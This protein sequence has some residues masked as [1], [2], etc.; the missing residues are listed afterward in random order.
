MQEERDYLVKFVFPELRRRCRSRGLEFTE[1]DL[2]WGVTEEQAERGEV[3]PLCLAEIDKCRPYFI[4][5]LGQRYGHVPA[6]MHPEL[7]V[8]QPWISNF[9]ERSITELEILHGALKTPE[10]ASRSFFYFRDP[11]YLDKVPAERREDY[12]S[13]DTASEAKLV[14]LKDQI[15]KSGHV[16]RE[17]FSDPQ[18]LGEMV[19][20][21][22]WE[23][24]TKEFPES[25]EPNR[26]DLMVAEHE[27]FARSRAH[28]YIGR[29]EYFDRLNT[30]AGDNG[31][32][33]VILGESGSG[34]SAL[35][36]NWGLKYREEHPKDFVFFHFAGSSPNSTDH[37]GLLSRLLA[38]LKRRYGF[39]E[40]VP[41]DSDKLRD[42]VPTW[43]ARAG[44]GE[45]RS[46]IILDGLN[47]LEDRDNALDLGWLPEHFPPQVCLIVST[48][49]GR[50]LAEIE[51]RKWQRLAVAA[52][53]VEERR[54]L[55]R[56]YLG[57]YRK[58]LNDKRVAQITSSLQTANPLYLRALLDELRVFGIHAKL[59][60]RIAHYLGA[61]SVPELYGLIL[62]RYEQDYE[63]D[64]PALVRDTM[65]LICSS[66]LGLPESELTLLL[67]TS[68]RP[69]PQAIWAPLYLAAEQNIVSRSGLLGF[70]HDFFR[71]AVAHRYLLSP[72]AKQ[73]AH[74]TLAQHFSSLQMGERKVAELPWQF[75]TAG[76]HENLKSCLTDP[77]LLIA[78]VKKGRLSDMGVYWTSL[79]HEYDPVPTYVNAAKRLKQSSEDDRAYSVYVGAVGQ[80]LE[81]LGSYKDAENFYGERLRTEIQL[82]KTA[83]IF[84]SANRLV[85]V[86][87]KQNKLTEAL[88]LVAGVYEGVKLEPNGGNGPGTIEFLIRM[89]DLYA[90]KGYFEAATETLGTAEALVNEDSNLSASTKG[91]LL[92]TQASIVIRFSKEITVRD[93]FTQN[94]LSGKDPKTTALQTVDFMRRE[95]GPRHPDYVSALRD[96]TQA[97]L[98]TKE[99]N[100]AMEV[101]AEAF[102]CS[103]LVFGAE[104]AETGKSMVCLADVYFETGQLERA[105]FLY[106]KAVRI[107]QMNSIDTFDH[108]RAVSRLAA[109]CRI[110]GR[111]AEVN[112]F[113]TMLDHLRKVSAVK[114]GSL[115]IGQY[116]ARTASPA[117]R[118]T[119]SVEPGFW[120]LMKKIRSF[121][122]SLIDKIGLNP[123]KI[124]VSLLG[125]ALSTGMALF[126]FGPFM[127]FLASHG[128]VGLIKMIVFGIG[129]F[130]LVLSLIGG[131]MSFFEAILGNPKEG[132]SIHFLG[133]SLAYLSYAGCFFL[134]R[135]Y[136]HQI[137]SE[138]TSVVVV[139]LGIIIFISSLIGILSHKTTS[140]LQE[141]TG[142]W[143]LPRF[144]LILPKS[145]LLPGALTKIGPRASSL[146]KSE[147]VDILFGNENVSQLNTS[148]ELPEGLLVYERLNSHIAGDSPITQAPDT[149]HHTVWFAVKA[150]LIAPVL[151]LFPSLCELLPVGVRPDN[152]TA[153][154]YANAILILFYVFFGNRMGRRSIALGKI[155]TIPVIGEIIA[156]KPPGFGIIFSLNFTVVTAVIATLTI[157]AAQGKLAGPD[158][159]NAFAW[160]LKAYILLLISYGVTKAFI[161]KISK[162]GVPANSAEE[163][164]KSAFSIVFA[165]VG[166]LFFPVILLLGRTILKNFGVEGAA[167]DWWP[168][169]M[170]ALSSVAFVVFGI[171]MARRRLSALKT[172]SVQIPMLFVAMLGVQLILGKTSGQLL[173][174]ATA[175]AG[176]FG[177]IVIVSFWLM[178][179]IHYRRKSKY[180]RSIQKSL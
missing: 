68:D 93:V 46:I 129:H 38:E 137:P 53:G 82:D 47:Q 76:D 166:G 145:M 170:F 59:D 102:T 94:D 39:T 172:M 128:D 92:R 48:L 141:S 180:D 54:Q 103:E 70:F 62:E 66:R 160:N 126:A 121:A 123:S 90:E 97:Y 157:L 164:E 20:A 110:T 162:L 17:R 133:K 96:L 179:R 75:Y 158:L 78:A 37:V 16:V 9:K 98:L 81:Y 63:Q 12:L 83:E 176:V 26:L 101:A 19:L 177:L 125:V 151:M 73:Q 104:H 178:R 87:A 131:Y 18:T 116:D 111:N 77:Q 64:R 147:L 169:L 152:R 79:K 44:A 88:K 130:A 28:V 32:P 119:S 142:R 49:P 50:S 89:A 108:A 175:A 155:L 51:R 135:D 107:F 122:M 15:R 156:R 6:E 118:L 120:R 149:K 36:A 117:D 134:L 52:L 42:A 11:G 56:D 115:N 5:I 95:F 150:G 13:E 80:V 41:A 34:K 74:R 25:G 23:A 60:E 72:E 124:I 4:G 31:M 30:H 21:D 29:Q 106:T 114:L 113:E 45:G 8:E 57:Q 173:A 171:E 35:L 136:L 99:N 71:Q 10:T 148:I 109:I 40:E 7:L 1:V 163:I 146:S 165:V 84:E 67:G 159:A 168:V 143:L 24:I 14:A 161:K 69:L 61:R 174:G 91:L 138:A 43:L 132:T 33:L 3:L 100:K 167:P 86:L 112:K 58:S 154:W 2:R 85:G 105:E 27:A 139:I 153:N 22:L 140:K 144:S 127:R 65:S 55:V